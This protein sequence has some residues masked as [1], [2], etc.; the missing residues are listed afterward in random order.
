MP[1]FRALA[2]AVLVLSVLLCLF[3][4][5]GDNKN[6][7]PVPEGYSYD[8]GDKTTDPV[9]TADP[10]VQVPANE[11]F[12][13]D[14]SWQNN[15]F[16]EYLYYNKELGGDTVRI[17]EIKTETAFEAEYPANGSFFY[18]VEDGGDLISYTGVPDEDTF[19]RAVMEGKSAADISSTFMKLSAVDASLPSLSNVLYMENETVAGRTCK[20]YIQRAYQDGAVTATVYIWIDAEFG[21]AA[22][23]ESY[24]KNNEL[25]TS[26]ELVQFEAGSVTD[27]RFDVDPGDYDFT[28]A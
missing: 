12:T 2:A 17:R 14:A 27:S 11:P 20:K 18:Y 3:A 1:K 5:C 8:S 25:E 22:K 28:E 16:A 26:W 10:S 21:F 24:D 23:C 7:T 19:T 15:F 13:V 6:P 9:S 4:G